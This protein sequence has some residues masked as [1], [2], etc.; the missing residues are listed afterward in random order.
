MCLEKIGNWE[1]VKEIAYGRR[2]RREIKKER[3]ES[4]CFSLAKTS[5]KR[6]FET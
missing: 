4:V 1:I 6:D 5:Q 3:E 2:S